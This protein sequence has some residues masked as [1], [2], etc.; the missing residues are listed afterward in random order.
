MLVTDL[1]TS[2]SCTFSPNAFLELSLQLDFLW[3]YG[4]QQLHTGFCFQH[5]W[6]LLQLFQVSPYCRELN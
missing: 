3:R 5:L 4:A 2:G 6:F 1:N